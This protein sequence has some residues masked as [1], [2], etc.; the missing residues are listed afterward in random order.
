MALDLTLM[1]FLY[2][3]TN[4]HGT[5]GKHGIFTDNFCVFGGFRGYLSRYPLSKRYSA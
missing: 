2:V 3:R 4:G 1:A 5:H